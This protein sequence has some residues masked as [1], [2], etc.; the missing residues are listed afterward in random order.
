[1]RPTPDEP[2]AAGPR[3]Q[4]DLVTVDPGDLRDFAK[5][6]DQVSQRI[7][8]IETPL[9]EQARQQVGFGAFDASAGAAQQHDRALR[10]SLAN[11][12]ALRARVAQLTEGTLLLARRYADTEELNRSVG[13]D[14]HA[15]LQR[16]E[17]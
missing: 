10:A 1:M 4:L 15:A 2:A 14:V 9:A 16:K 17:A 5:L 8:E 7:A 6:L 12:R 11:V 3:P 13:A